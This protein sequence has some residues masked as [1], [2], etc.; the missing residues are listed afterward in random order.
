MTRRDGLIHKEGIKW[1]H[2]GDEGSPA[3]QKFNSG[4]PSPR[5]VSRVQGNAIEEE[6]KLSQQVR[7]DPEMEEE[8][9]QVEREIR[10][11]RLIW[12]PLLVAAQTE[13]LQEEKESNYKDTEVDSAAHVLEMELMAF[14]KDVE[15]LEYQSLAE[16]QK[17]ERREKARVLV[18]KMQSFNWKAIEERL[19]KMQAE[20]RKRRIEQAQQELL[21]SL[22]RF[23]APLTQER[24]QSL[25]LLLD[26][27]DASQPGKGKQKQK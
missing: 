12:H 6:A 1:N 26:E 13:R 18:T 23:R 9:K 25:S 22:Q 10:I 5:F 24:E 3:V 11:F 21:D 4:F 16:A 27:E 2:N 7:E 19:E 8:R 15:V 17:S 14:Q 20:K